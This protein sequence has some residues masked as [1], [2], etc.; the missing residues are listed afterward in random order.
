MALPVTS[1]SKGLNNVT[2]PVRLG[3]N[4]Y[5]RADNIDVT[6][7]GS[8][9]RR[10]GF[11]RLMAAAM[12]GAYSSA[13]LTRLYVAADG[14]LCAVTPDMGL[15]PL[16]ALQSS[17]PLQWAQLNDHIFFTN[18][19]DSGVIDVD[20]T[21]MPWAL[22]APPAPAV[23]A[24]PG[25]LPP[26]TYHVRLTHMWP[27]G[28]EG[29]ASTEAA[30]TLTTPG[31][32]SITDIELGPTGTAR[33]Y[34][35][36]ADST[37]YQLAA[38]VDTTALM[39]SSTPDALGAELTNAFMDTVPFGADVIAAWRGRT[40]A[41]LYLPNEDQTAIFFSEPL[42]SHLF[43]Y[44]QSFISVPGRAVALAPHD[45]ALLIGT[46]RKLYAYTPERLVTLADYGVVPGMPWAKD[47]ERLL[48][49]TLRGLCQYPD[50]KNLTER[51]VS[52]APGTHAAAAVI[53]QDGQARFVA[54]LHAGG[55][56]FNQRK[57]VSP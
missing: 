13:D 4:W 19:Q 52:V 20:D 34:I 14:V 11:S 15:R 29:C 3:L 53:E 56:A 5:A 12:S 48:V 51:R 46:D 26:G 9:K 10:E 2:D 7:T 6:Q 32:L 35:A 17:T 41:S 43:N 40:F 18:G 30:I 49:W 31:A 39:W 21:V 42:A 25:N 16:Q 8:V 55:I 22:P 1:R 23:T 33:V 44:A 28:R 45:E 57:E 38:E 50:F 24:A 54:A 27:D 37:L 47:G 36:P